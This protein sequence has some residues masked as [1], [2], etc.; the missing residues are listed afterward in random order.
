VAVLLTE[1]FGKKRAFEPILPI[2]SSAGSLAVDPQVTSW[3][4]GGQ[5][6]DQT[7]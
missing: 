5:K 1:L 6:S 2:F 4:Q 3:V 7:F